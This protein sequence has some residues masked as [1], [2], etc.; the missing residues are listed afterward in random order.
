MTDS[1]DRQEAASRGLMNMPA[2]ALRKHPRAQ[3]QS[4]R[5]QAQI[6]N[7]KGQ[8]QRAIDATEAMVFLN[9]KHNLGYPT[10]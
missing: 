9:E 1:T 4:L 8:T 2:S 6:A 3:V 5:K 10:V 7:R